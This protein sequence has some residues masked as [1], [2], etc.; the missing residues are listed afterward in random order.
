[1]GVDVGVPDAFVTLGAGTVELGHCD[2]PC[3][4]EASLL[5]RG[6]VVDALLV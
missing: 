3:R 1:M 4:V 6:R 5:A 2:G